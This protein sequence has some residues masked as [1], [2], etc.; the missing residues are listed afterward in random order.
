MHFQDIKT[1]RHNSDEKNREEIYRREH[2]L[3]EKEKESAQER[4]SRALA[5][6]ASSGRLT[7][8]QRIEM[9]VDRDES[10][11]LKYWH[12]GT[13]RSFDGDRKSSRALGVFCGMGVVAGRSV[14]VIANDNTQSAGAWWPGAPEKI[15]DAQNMAFRLHIPVIYL[16]E[17]AGLYLAYQEQTYAGGRG[18]GAI[19]ERQAQLNRGGVVQ[20]A[21]VFGDCIA[22]GGYMPILCDKIVMTEQSS[23]CIGG[24]AISSA[25]C[26]RQNESIGGPDVHVAYSQTV[27]ERAPD[28]ESAI[29]WIRREIDKLPTPATAYYRIS[30]PVL[31]HFSIGD[32][33]DILPT[34]LSRSYDVEEVVA[35][36]V[37]ASQCVPLLEDYGEEVYGCF[38][39]V[40]G[41]PVVV[42]ANR[43]RTVE[44][45]GRFKSGGILYREGITKIR[46][47]AAAANH[48]GIPTIWLQDVSGFDIGAE[49]E[50]D[51]LLRHG[52]GILHE[53]AADESRTPA[54]LTIVLR[55]ASGAGYYAMKGAPFHPAWRVVTALSRIEVMRSDVLASALYDKKIARIRRD[56]EN[57][58]RHGEPYDDLGGAC[59]TPAI[60][61]SNGGEGKER[62]DKEAYVARLSRERKELELARSELSV[63]QERNGQ[64]YSALVRGDVDTFV[65]LFR[66]RLAVVDFVRAAWQERRPVKP[67]RLWEIW[68]I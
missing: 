35:R 15:Q 5:R 29:S 8:W 39:A 20:L 18:A 62:E 58:R 33:Y 23:V 4:S 46:R 26:G 52:A 43:A 21:A 9:L 22:G 31:P 41:L 53:I 36:L 50:R 7:A 61:S 24:S 54:A 28:D 11:N 44:S 45:D 38:A 65:P 48:D 32:L 68:G 17:C 3:Q 12:I 49:A 64:A 30:E 27:D 67:K 56:I 6:V 57:V 60:R 59:G 25:A 40:D 1:S 55:K 66:L 13:M 42:I 37:D 19:F 47:I 63:V 16:V 51:G 34:D 10:G 2:Q 14:V